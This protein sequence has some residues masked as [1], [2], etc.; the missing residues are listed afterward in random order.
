ML[1][2]SLECCKNSYSNWLKHK[3]KKKWKHICKMRSPVKFKD[4]FP[5]YSEVV[6]LFPLKNKETFTID[7]TQKQALSAT[8]FLNR[9]QVHF[10]LHL[11][12]LPM[13]FHLWHQSL[14]EL[15]YLKMGPHGAQPPP[16]RVQLFCESLE[17]WA[18][19]KT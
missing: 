17:K 12:G 9:R 2:T 10:L 7:H 14:E 5:L 16:M 11:S 18:I 3:H 1:D 4:S 19:W 6:V 15:K 13:Y 8:Q